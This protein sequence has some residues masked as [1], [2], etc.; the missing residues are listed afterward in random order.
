MTDQNFE[1][2]FLLVLD[3]SSIE[4][5]AVLASLDQDFS[6]TA[7]VAAAVVHA[8]HLSLVAPTLQV[9]HHLSLLEIAVAAAEHCEEQRTVALAADHV[10]NSG[11]QVAGTAVD[12]IIAG[13]Q[14]GS[15]IADPDLDRMNQGSPC[16]KLQ[17][18]MKEY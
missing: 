8:D 3:F 12:L 1:V 13:Y 10:G 11:I 2:P 9:Q 4:V 15:R 17:M 16:L 14:K 6:M 7:T 5:V 18:K